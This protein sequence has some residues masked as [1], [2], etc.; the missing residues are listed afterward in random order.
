M[1]AATELVQPL[2]APAPALAPRARLAAVPAPE[3]PRAPLVPPRPDRDRSGC[4]R[5]SAPVGLAEVHLLRPPAE[6]AAGSHLT[7]RGIAVLALAVAGAA[8]ALVWFAVRSV[9]PAAQSGTPGPAVVTVHAGDT[10]WGIAGR[11]A[12]D[13]DP[14]AEVATLQRLNGLGGVALEPGQRLRVR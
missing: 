3:R 9:P 13:V 5:P 14:R 7:R 6:T 11:V 10:L 8:L 1:S 2:P 12:P 4:R